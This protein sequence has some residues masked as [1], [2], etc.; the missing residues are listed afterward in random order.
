MRAYTY[1]KYKC[2][3]NVDFGA[4]IPSVERLIRHACVFN[5]GEIK[6]IKHSSFLR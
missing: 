5:V 1:A 6:E 4:C 2:V 3:F